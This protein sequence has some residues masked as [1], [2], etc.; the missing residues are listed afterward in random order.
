[1]PNAKILFIED[2]ASESMKIK[3]WLQSWEYDVFTAAV[4]EQEAIKETEIINPDLIV[5]DS[6]Q[7]GNDKWIYTVQEIQNYLDVPVLYLL[8]NSDGK[9]HENNLKSFTGYIWKPLDH[10][11]LKH[12]VD[13]V[14]YR[15]KMERALQESENR[16]RLLMD[17]MEDSMAVVDYDGV[18]LLLNEAA[19]KFLG[20]EVEDFVG[21]TMWDLFP[22][23][24]ADYYMNNICEVIETGNGR[25]LEDRR[26]LNGKIIWFRTNIQPIIHSGDDKF[27]VQ[28]ISRDITSLK[29]V[30]KALK[31]SKDFFYGTLNDMLT[32]V[33]VMKPDGEIIFVNNTILELSGLKLEDVVG[34]KF[35]DGE[36]WSYSEATKQLI[37]KDIELCASGETLSHELLGE[38]LDGLIWTEFSMHPIYDRKENVKY[39]V[40]EGRDI[41]PRKEAEK[42]FRCE[43]S[44]FQTLTENSP[45]GLALID[46]TGTY[47][48]INP[49]FKEVFGYS[50]DEIP[51]GKEWFRKAYP[52]PQ[53]RH[54]VIATWINDFKDANPGEKKPRTFKVNCKD[55]KEKTIYFVPVLLETGEYLMSVEDISERRKM[56]EALRKSEK[57]FR[58]VAQSATVGIIINDSKGR[59]IFCNDILQV[60]FGYS[61]TELV[62]KPV[63]SLMPGYKEILKK[64][65]YNFMFVDGDLL[66]GKVF[67]SYGL[68][69]DGSEFPIEFSVTKWGAE[70]EKFTT[71]IIRDITDRRLTEYEL[72][73]REELFRQMAETIEEVFWIINPS[74]SQIL[75]I[76]PA[77]EKLWGRSIESLYDNPKSWIDSIH[78]DDR[79]KV[80]ET[81]FEKSQVVKKGSERG[82][83]YRIIRPDGSIKWIWVRSFQ[84]L[85]ENRETYRIVGIA[86]D[87]TNRKDIEKKLKESVKEIEILVE[88]I[89][90][91]KK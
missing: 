52:D 68:R 27:T 62:G 58:T 24:N 75:Y 73:K 36:W 12:A 45:F 48:Y 59:I 39:L 33:A 11:E 81:I 37:K 79:Q 56:E 69:K 47:K 10:I 14:L 84:V 3:K 17:N 26:L 6:G 61:E 13:M 7:D 55:G 41:T 86:M 43:K 9:I 1:M 71:L 82:I 29:N 64:Q 28:L 67:E 66:F 19:A 15:H 16:N 25:I 34:M 5:L 60:I 40:A 63:V 78:P 91:L 42:A 54:Q 83:E 4:S 32:F 46:N 74:M 21:K 87:I 90:R 38:V 85:N 88:K 65:E 20:G 80:I 31:E 44:R 70:R 72:K 22:K 35:Y 51:N 49:K 57:R 18:L 23:E 53:Y 8:S 76:S 77:Y 89:N 50:L 2:N 30:D